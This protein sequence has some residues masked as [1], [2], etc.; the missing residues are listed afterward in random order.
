[1]R[2]ALWGMNSA[3]AA[4][5]LVRPYIEAVMKAFGEITNGSALTPEQIEFIELVIEELTQN[6]IVP[7]ERLF[8]PP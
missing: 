3:C 8:Q 4:W 6:G 1:M 2:L 5:Q 7:P